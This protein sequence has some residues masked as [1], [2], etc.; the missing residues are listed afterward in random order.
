MKS[1]LRDMGSIGGKDN[2]KSNVG[3]K[4][5][6]NQANYLRFSLSF[7]VQRF[8]ISEAIDKQHC[9]NKWIIDHFPD[10]RIGL[11][12]VHLYKK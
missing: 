8:L 6:K 2:I 5:T 11:Q 10:K 12:T 3:M 9:N 7:H 4:R 1:L